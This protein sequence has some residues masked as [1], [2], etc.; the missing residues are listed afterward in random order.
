MTSARIPAIILVM[1]ETT[2]AVACRPTPT[3]P[4]S[5][6]SDVTADEFLKPAHPPGTIDHG[7]GITQVFDE[8]GNERWYRNGLRH[9]DGD[10]PAATW[11]N[12]DQSWYRN[13]RH[14]RDGDKPAIVYADG[15]QEWWVDGR[16]HRDGGKPAYISW[17]GREEYWLNGKRQ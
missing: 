5:T 10:K 1:T 8:D 15:T 17:D 2:A 6:D 9:R 14:H 12:G 4:G 7:N 11:S 3:I 16:L 13:G